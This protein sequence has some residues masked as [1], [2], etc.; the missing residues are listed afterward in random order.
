MS[1]KITDGLLKVTKALPNGAATV[2]SDGLDLGGGDIVAP[3]EVKISA[4]ALV[5]GD[6][7]NADTM[8]Y[9]LQMDTDPA[10]GSPT[11]LLDDL[12]IQTGANGAGAAAATKTVRLPVATERYLRL[13]V[14]N[15]AAGDASDKSATLELLF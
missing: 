15:S 12:I 13:K 6:L 7:G 14:V 3:F 1:F 8:K 9:S 5:V 10:F 11:E 4:P 2:Y